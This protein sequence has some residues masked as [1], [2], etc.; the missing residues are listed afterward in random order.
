MTAGAARGVRPAEKLNCTS[1]LLRTRVL[2]RDVAVHV[3][4]RVTW[5]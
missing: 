2:A 5:T 3:S 4:S 1:G